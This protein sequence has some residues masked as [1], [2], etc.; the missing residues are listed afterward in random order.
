MPINVPDDL[1]AIEM[2]QKERIDIKERKDALRQDIRPLELLLLNLMPKKDDPEF[3]FIQIFSSSPLQINLTLM[4][5]ESYTPKNW[6]LNH[7]VNFYSKL[8]DVRDK[9][10]DALIITGAPVERLAFEEVK[11]WEELVEIMEWSVSHCY[12]RLGI[13]WG[14]QALLEHF[15]GVPKHKCTKKQFGVFQ[16][17]LNERFEGRITRGFPECFPM[18]VSRHAETHR[19]DLENVGI[20]VLAESEECGVGLALDP[21]NGDLFVL[22][23]LEYGADTLSME[24]RRD[25]DAKIPVD[26][27][28]GYFPEDDPEKKPVNF[29]RAYAF[30]LFSNWINDL[31]QSTPYD[32]CVM[33]ERVLRREKLSRGRSNRP[34]RPNSVDAAHLTGDRLVTDSRPAR[35]NGLRRAK[36]SALSLAGSKRG[37]VR[38]QTQEQIVAGQAT[39]GA[40]S[41]RSAK[42]DHTLSGR[43]RR[44]SLESPTRERSARATNRTASAASRVLR[45]PRSR[46]QGSMNRSIGQ[47][48]SARLRRRS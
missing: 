48:Q 35:A 39:V 36:A 30:L 3:Q 44:A 10:F 26:L 8:A 18:P 27:P 2:L 21:K 9:H 31:Y 46:I 5:T 11:Y 1:P 43:S 4:T 32:L 16:H 14:A 37:T 25:K 33:E 19:T 7:F 12:R 24:Y 23:H 20:E 15:H 34:V 47:G 45:S 38:K 40:W 42:R 29:W 6:P 13:C 22:N 41:T 28:K 17:K